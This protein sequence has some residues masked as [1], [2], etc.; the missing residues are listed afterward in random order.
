MEVAKVESIKDVLGKDYKGSGLIYTSRSGREIA[1][2]L[3]GCEI[4]FENVPLND[5]PTFIDFCEDHV[6]EFIKHKQGN[7]A[8]CE[9]GLM[10]RSDWQYQITHPYEDVY[11]SVEL[12]KRGVA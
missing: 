4:T 9:I 12:R 7:M 11:F 3:N 6:D 8:E 2:S 5:T 10:K 1:L